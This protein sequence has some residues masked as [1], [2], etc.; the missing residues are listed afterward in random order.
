MGAF[1]DKPK[2]DKKNEKGGNSAFK[3]ATSSMQG[4]RVDMEDSHSAKVGLP[5]LPQWS[6]F[7]VFDGHAGSKIAE[8][9][10]HHLIEHVL[11][12]KKFENF[13]NN[14]EKGGEMPD[15]DVKEAIRDGFLNL[16]LKMREISSTRNDNDRSGSTATCVL[17]SPQKYY[18]VNCGDSRSLLCRDSKVHF[19]TE[20][21]KPNNPLEKERILN[22]G[23]SVMIQRVNGSLAV[24]RALGDYEYKNV[25]SKG[26]TEQLVSPDPEI[27]VVE[28]HETDQFIVL[29]CDGIF[30][31]SSNDELSDFIISRMEICDDLVKVC[32][33][34]V[35]TSLNK[36]SRDNMTL[37]ILAFPSA[38]K[39]NSEAKKREEEM[40][41]KLKN[42]VKE[43][44]S[45]VKDEP[46]EIGGLMQ[47]VANRQHEIKNLPPGGGVYA[48]R[49][50]IESV[51]KEVYTGKTASEDS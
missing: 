51:F 10:S 45:E 44:C 32:N 24:S 36:G 1:L 30:D 34:V 47:T 7:A 12:H 48:K 37:I 23:G 35:D 50:L 29:A 26:P 9:S 38:P 20:D 42:L 22:A 3:F 15:E 33:S 39:S 11:S 13:I 49:F 21:H 2:T 5:S 25:E 6:F 8:Y 16:D 18:F 43:I 19:S 4:W 14:G 40:E 28:R 31:V 17:I 27:S 46:L 41:E